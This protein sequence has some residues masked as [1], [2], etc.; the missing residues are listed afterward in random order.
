MSTTCVPPAPPAPTV[1]VRRKASAY[2]A[3]TK[4]RI[5]ELLLVVAAPT[6]IL[7]QNGIPD[8][9]LFFATILG[10]AMSAGSAGELSNQ[11]ALVF[12]YVLGV[13]SIVWLAVFTNLVAAALS[14]LAILLYAVFYSII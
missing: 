10:G 3:L 4:P 6:M 14:L 13:A 9:W 2:I 12:A 11:E 8:L 1:S 5:I 7:A